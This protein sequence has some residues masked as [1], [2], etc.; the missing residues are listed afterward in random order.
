MARNYLHV[1]EEMNSLQ[2]RVNK[3]K[4]M[5]LLAS[6]LV[7]FFLIPLSEAFVNHSSRWNEIRSI[8]GQK[9][10]RQS[11]LYMKI[12]GQVS[13]KVIVTGA[14]GRTGSLVFFPPQQ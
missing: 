13:K 6:L 3:P 2:Y 5:I 9:I 8:T 7:G 1:F 11:P 10:S 14:A 4:D 12:P